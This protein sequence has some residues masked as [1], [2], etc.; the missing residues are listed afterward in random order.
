MLGAS[1]ASSSG[2]RSRH[3]CLRC[4]AW[5]KDTRTSASPGATT[6]KRGSVE[7]YARIASA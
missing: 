1:F 7:K 4:V 2:V 5:M 3:A 6:E